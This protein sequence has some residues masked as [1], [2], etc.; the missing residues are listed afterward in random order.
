MTG[1]ADTF[2]PTFYSHRSVFITGGTGFLGKALCEKLLRS[3]PDIEEIYLLIRPK[4]GLTITD[5]V[6]KMLNNKLFD[7]LRRER[8]TS[9]EKII[10]ISGNVSIKDLGL[11]PE[12]RKMLSEKVSIIFHVA[13]SVRFDESLKDAIFT[14]LRSTRDVCILAQSMKNIVALVYVSSAFTQCDKPV[15]DEVFYPL[16]NVDW[17]KTIHTAEKIDN[18][19][20]KVF[21]AKYIHPMPNT[22]V[23]T[24][25]L[26]ENVI[27]DFSESLPCVI[28][29]PSI[30]VP[31]ISDPIPGW[32]DNF[33]GP[34]GLLVGGGTGILRVVHLDANV[35][36][37]FIP[38]DIVI[39]VM[40]IAAWKRGMKNTSE[41]NS[42][43]IYNCFINNTKSISLRKLIRES[44]RVVYDIPL[45]Q[46]I[47]K[48]HTIMTNSGLVY[49][50]LVLVLH[51]V[52]ALFIDTVLKILRLRPML[53]KL[54]RRIYMS[55]CALSFFVT[56][57]WQFNTT[58]LINI[59]ENLS[60]ANE[61]DFEYNNILNF[62][63]EEIL[64]RGIIS[65]KLYLLNEDMSRLEQL[66][67][68][69]KKMD[70]LH[71]SIKLFFVIM[72]CYI[73][74]SRL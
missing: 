31:S 43:H 22:Y 50:I 52:P 6:K 4:K 17:K 69:R 42:L 65:T 14:N 36:S 15:V 18:E 48:P 19:I 46:T 39:K 1:D 47:W 32:L 40:I 35:F 16:E 56:H 60:A 8:P 29:R 26:A 38:I 7:L 67:R 5:R 44:F 34:M 72:L 12:D 62:D 10:P 3:C 53:L 57:F 58:N 28:I 59:F 30:V 25:R 45:E 54:Q 21:T 66:R 68:Y 24:K 73:L 71:K 33:N 41:D 63:T 20:L 61:K 55:N 64:R 70:W 51:I 11:L 13:A 23:F 49:Y 37:D 27:N 74:Y 9:F 2:I